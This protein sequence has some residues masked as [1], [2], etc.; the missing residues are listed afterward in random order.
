MLTYDCDWCRR[1]KKR[2][3]RWILGFAAERVGATGIQREISI[4]SVW[5]EKAAGHPLAVHFCSEDHKSAYIEALFNC[6]TTGVA[7]RRRARVPNGRGSSQTSASAVCMRAAAPAAELGSSQR[8]RHSRR[9]L[10]SR[11]ARFTEQDA[12]RS[13]GLGILLD[14]HRDSAA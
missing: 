12:I 1:R 6:A 5:S 13:H 2:G 14:E 7:K 4:A 8:T 9:A 3:E 10:R 11:N